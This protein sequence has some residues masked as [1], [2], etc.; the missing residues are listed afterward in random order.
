MTN[1]KPPV[2]GAGKE[3]LNLECCDIFNF[4]PHGLASDNPDCGRDGQGS[5]PREGRC[6]PRAELHQGA[7]KADEEHRHVEQAEG[8]EPGVEGDQL[9]PVS[10]LEKDDTKYN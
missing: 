6:D 3:R 2:R 1:V 7:D 9:L 5:Q 4:L 8:Q 10:K